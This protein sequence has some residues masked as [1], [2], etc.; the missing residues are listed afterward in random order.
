[1]LRAHPPCYSVV[2]AAF[3]RAGH[4]VS[5]LEAHPFPGSCVGGA[6]RHC[7]GPKRTVF[8]TGVRPLDSRSV[9]TWTSAEAILPPVP[10]T[11]AAFARCVAAAAADKTLASCAV[12]YAQTVGCC[13][14]G[15]AFDRA[16]FLAVGATEPAGFDFVGAALHRAHLLLLLPS[17]T[18]W[19][20][21]RGQFIQ[22]VF[23]CGQEDADS[24]VNVVHHVY[25]AFGV[26]VDHCGVE[27]RILPPHAHSVTNRK[28]SLR[29]STVRT[30]QR[31]VNLAVSMRRLT[32]SACS[33][34]R[35][36]TASEGSCV[37]TIAS[38]I[39]VRSKNLNINIQICNVAV[40]DAP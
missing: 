19:L 17:P 40:L 2:A 25:R 38:K 26:H 12:F 7:A 29:H 5:M 23:C 37:V 28:V 36:Y 21:L 31:L 27:H 4:F 34:R 20:F 6:P 11:K 15:A 3:G 30:E 1:M 9:A 35:C 14:G 8:A 39:K 22:A 24:A 33:V 16:L 18:P 10:P 13:F 32:C